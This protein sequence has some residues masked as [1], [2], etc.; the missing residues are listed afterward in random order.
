VKIHVVTRLL[1]TGPSLLNNSWSNMLCLSHSSLER[2]R[3]KFHIA[4]LR[5]ALAIVHLL[6]AFPEITPDLV[7]INLLQ[8]RGVALIFMSWHGK[9]K[10]ALCILQL[11]MTEL[12]QASPFYLMLCLYLLLSESWKVKSV[13]CALE[14]VVVHCTFL[15][16]SR[17]KASLALQ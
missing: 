9:G 15:I 17:N 14:N 16:I 6:N 12:F 3:I 7:K 8:P 2:I 10:P 13:L 4:R 11:K 5:H 1:L